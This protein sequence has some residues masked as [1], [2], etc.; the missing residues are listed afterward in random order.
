MWWRYRQFRTIQPHLRLDLHRFECSWF[1]F[2]KFIPNFTFLVLFLSF[3]GI[4]FECQYIFIHLFWIPLVFP[5]CSG[6]PHMDINHGFDNEHFDI[7][8]EV[9]GKVYFPGSDS[10]LWRGCLRSLWRY[11]FVHPLFQ[12]CCNKASYLKW[13]FSNIY[14]KAKSKIFHFTEFRKQR[15]WKK[16]QNQLNYKKIVEGTENWELV[17]GLINMI[18]F[19]YCVVYA[20][21]MILFTLKFILCSIIYIIIC[22]HMGYVF[23]YHWVEMCYK[24]PPKNHWFASFWQLVNFLRWNP[25]ASPKHLRQQDFT[26]ISKIILDQ[27]G[28][29]D[30]K[31]VLD[32]IIILPN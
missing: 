14:W 32:I 25:S 5:G 11:S 4:A 6:F 17:C 3:F 29:T 7:F 28:L 30:F 2:K 31:A 22:Q 21:Y 19:I 20:A 13:L 26:V 10:L 16:S 24:S 15:K 12:V 1:D 23:V 18:I 9:D 8:Y 27:F